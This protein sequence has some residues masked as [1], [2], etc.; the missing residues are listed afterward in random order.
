MDED[1]WVPSTA[2]AATHACPY[3]QAL[4]SPASQR[5]SSSSASTCTCYC[6][7]CSFVCPA[8]TLAKAAAANWIQRDESADGRVST[9]TQGSSKA[10]GQSECSKPA[11]SRSGITCTTASASTASTKDDHDRHD[12]GSVSSEQGPPRTSAATFLGAPLCP[13]DH[14]GNIVGPSCT[15][16]QPLEQDQA[17]ASSDAQ[18]SA[19]SS[20]ASAAAVAAASVSPV[21]TATTG[22]FVCL[23]C[24]TCWY[25]LLTRI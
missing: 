1:S 10:C 25:L 3:A 13:C 19:R 12:R 8:T 16:S 6:A 5:A 9:C 22:R 7:C 24:Q 20:C 4:A 18:R 23:A 15:G 17:V 21:P 14:K 2:T 11:C